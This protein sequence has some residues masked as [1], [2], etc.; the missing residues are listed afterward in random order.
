MTGSFPCLCLP[1]QVSFHKYGDFF[2]GTG[3]VKDVGVKSGKNYSVNCPLRE[4]MDDKSYKQVFQP[5]LQ[6]V[7][8]LFQP[9]AVVLQCGADSLTGDRLGCFNLTLKARP[10]FG[11]RLRSSHVDP[12]GALPLDARYSNF[13]GGP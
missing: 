11:A 3:D 4:G 12:E 10:E 8:D 6:K 2:P 13:P 9:G 5:V 7:M 1:L